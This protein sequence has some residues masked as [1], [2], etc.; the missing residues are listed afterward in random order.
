MSS[1]SPRPASE[2]QGQVTS[3]LLLVTSGSVLA[4]SQV[5]GLIWPSWLPLETE[6]MTPVG[7]QEQLPSASCEG[8]RRL[9]TPSQKQ[10]QLGR[11]QGPPGLLL[12]ISGDHIS[13]A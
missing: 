8:R 1:T 4:A 5:G 10:Q 9:L 12:L 2:D 3:S 7:N 13:L 6:A 11:G